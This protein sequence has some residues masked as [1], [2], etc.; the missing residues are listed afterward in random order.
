MKSIFLSVFAL[1]LA[2]FLAS[3]VYAADNGGFGTTY[4]TGKAPAA[5]AGA[6][7]NNLVAS[8]ADAAAAALN[9]IAPAAGGPSKDA[10][11]ASKGSTGKDSYVG[12]SKNGKLMAPP[13]DPALPGRVPPAQ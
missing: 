4:F 8:D 9:A 13:S 12:Q 6:P 7:A 5:L 1:T 10:S 3:P 11:K 2:V